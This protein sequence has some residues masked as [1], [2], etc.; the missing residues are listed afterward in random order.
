M[1]IKILLAFLGIFA[2]ALCCFSAYVGQKI[3]FA[4]QWPLFE[5][6]RTTSSI[7]FAV[8]GAWLAIVYPER[9]KLSFGRPA[10]TDRNSPNVGLLLYPAGCSTIILI[11]VLFAGIIAPII[12]HIPQAMQYLAFLRGF[13]FF[14]LTVLTLWQIAVVVTTLYP[15]DLVKVNTDR[16]HAASDFRS[17]RSRL[18]QR[19]DQE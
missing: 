19:S 13:S 8:V 14:I 16:E 12:K 18:V 15:A 5:A 3:P 11:C 7:I 1:K 6:L 9:M 4:E 17:N 10:G 2:A